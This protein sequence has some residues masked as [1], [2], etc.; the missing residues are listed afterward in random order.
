MAALAAT[1]TAQVSAVNSEAESLPPGLPVPVYASTRGSTVVRQDSTAGASP[2]HNALGSVLVIQGH[3]RTDSLCAALAAA[4]V[5]GA[6]EAGVEV[7]QLILSGLDF[8]PNVREPSPAQQDLEPDLVYAKKLVERADHLVFIY[9]T[10]W[11]TMP[12]L[13][14]GFLDRL[15]VPGWAFWFHSDHKHWDQ[16]L[17]GRTAE[18]ITT[19]DTP[20]WVH[21][22]INRRPGHNAMCRATLGFC[23]IRTTAETVFGP[24][25]LSDEQQRAAWLRETANRGRAL[26]HGTLSSAQR[27][28]DA[29]AAWLRSLRLQFYPMTWATYTLGALLAPQFSWLYY[30]LG[31]AILFFLEMATV[32]SNEVQDYDSDR[33]NREFSPFNGGSRVLVTGALSARQLNV[34]ALVATFLATL[35]ALILLPQLSSPLAGTALLALLY[36]MALGYTLP[37]LRLSYRGLGEINVAATHSILVLLCGFVFQGGTW[38]GAEVWLLALPVFLSVFAAITLA[39]IPDLEADRG[40]GKRTLAVRFGPAGAAGVATAATVAAALSAV[41]LEAAGF[42]YYGPAMAGIVLH[43]LILVT[44][45]VRYAAGFPAPARINSLLI[46]SLSFILWFCVAPLLLF[47]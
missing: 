18:L 19:M 7:T 34:G 21:R 47:S 8:D 5:D 9:P 33:H 27:L 41:T 43:A 46:V 26:R 2:S 6:R 37:P 12:A 42:R 45:L 36:V 30:G 1:G 20:P 13:L 38:H 32:W 40:A 3:P 44:I 17:T 23:G 15:L 25:A 31:Y 29:G 4:Y 11:G 10:W 14:K 35:G 39:G 24:V 28:G 22:L 16:L